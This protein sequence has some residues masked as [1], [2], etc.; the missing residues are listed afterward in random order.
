MVVWR[1]RGLQGVVGRGQQPPLAAFA[2]EAVSATSRAR[3]VLLAAG[4]Q[5]PGGGGCCWPEK[6]CDF[7]GQEVLGHEVFLGPWA[8]DVLPGWDLGGTLC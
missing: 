5:G 3:P 4:V 6:C 8:G 7:Q 1:A 2:E